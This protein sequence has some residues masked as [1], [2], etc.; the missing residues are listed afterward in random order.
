MWIWIALATLG[1]ATPGPLDGFRANYASIKA[2]MDY[3]YL[4]G[5]LD[6]DPSRIWEERKPVFVENRASAIVGHWACDGVSELYRYRSSDEVL[7]LAKQNPPRREASKMLFQVRVVDKVE[8][9]WDGET[10]ASHAA[11]PYNTAPEKE[12]SWTAIQISTVS[13]EPATLTDGRGP[14]YWGFSYTFPQILKARFP[15]VIPTRRHSQRGGHAVEVETYRQDS[16]NG[17]RLQFEVSYDPMIGYLPRFARII[18][19]NPSGDAIAKE[20]Y[21]VEA[22]HCA[23]G[24]F[25]PTEWYDTFVMV[26]GFAKRFPNYDAD[27]VLQTEGRVGAGHFLASSFGNLKGP[28]ALT[29]LKDV[30]TISTPGGWIPLRSKNALTLTNIKTLAG[31]RLSNPTLHTVLPHLDATEMHEF[32]APAEG[33]GRSTWLLVLLSLAALAVI[34]FRCRGWVKKSSDGS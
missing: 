1:Q 21:L 4:G 20:M 2:A 7:E 6:G 22:K 30:N 32:D 33:G 28:V 15:G 3:Q 24:G 12:F 11:S 34:G 13:E 10:L 31:T 19:V 9:L 5:T 25:V 26:E 16:P 27:T 17:A 18:S 23:A 8:A 14:F 29:D